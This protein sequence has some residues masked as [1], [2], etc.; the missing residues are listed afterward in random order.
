MNNAD[1]QDQPLD[2]DQVDVNQHGFV[3]YPTGHVYGIASFT[4]Q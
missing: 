4:R 2:L 3:G 1:D